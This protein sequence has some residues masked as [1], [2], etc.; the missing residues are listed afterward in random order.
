MAGIYDLEDLQ[1][2]NRFAQREGYSGLGEY[3]PTLRTWNISVD[4]AAE[5]IR[6]G[7]SFSDY[8]QNPSLLDEELPDNV[9]RIADLYHEQNER[10]AQQ[11]NRALEERISA[12]QEKTV[13]HKRHFLHPMFYGIASGLAAAAVLI[14]LSSLPNQEYAPFSEASLIHDPLCT[15]IEGLYVCLDKSEHG[16]FF[17]SYWQYQQL[18][19]GL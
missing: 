17:G 5:L 15:N 3:L 19:K 18:K 10:I 9:V 8:R 7:I 13:P 4:I 14:G 16:Q 1:T 6:K 12:P 2:L 11:R